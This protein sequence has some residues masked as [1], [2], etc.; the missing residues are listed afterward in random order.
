MNE[1]GSY[2]KNSTQ[3]TAVTIDRMMGYRLVSNWA[4]VKWVFS[5]VNVDLFHVSDRPWEVVFNFFCLYFCSAFLL[6]FG[7][8][9]EEDML[10]FGANG[11]D[12]AVMSTVIKLFFVV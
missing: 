8:L 3:M 12:L 9:M 10:C 7:V 5:S 6:C 2:W 11:C 1:V 4:I